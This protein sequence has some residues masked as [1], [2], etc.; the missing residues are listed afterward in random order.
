[1]TNYLLTE[2]KSIET[3]TTGHAH[4]IIYTVDRPLV[5]G[6]QVQ[7]LHDIRVVFW[8]LP[9][10][11]A[12]TTY[13]EYNTLLHHSSLPQKIGLVCPIINVSSLG[14]GRWAGLCSVEDIVAG[15][16]C[17]LRLRQTHV[18]WAQFKSVEIDDEPLSS[19][20]DVLDSVRSL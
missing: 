2:I 18:W 19:R 3:T 11:H 7:A 17:P 9:K 10:L 16:R 20:P 4:K 12:F 8:L 13:I 5:T 6:I 14:G 1:M 15:A